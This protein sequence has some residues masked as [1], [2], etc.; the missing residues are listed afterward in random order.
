MAILDKCCPNSDNPGAALTRQLLMLGLSIGI[1]LCFLLAG[2]C[3]P[4]FAGIFGVRQQCGPPAA[5]ALRVVPGF[6]FAPTAP[7]LQRV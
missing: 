3:F 2:V 1:S 5:T 4:H 6:I 7:F